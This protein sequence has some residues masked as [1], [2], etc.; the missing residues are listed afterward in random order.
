MKN[1]KKNDNLNNTHFDQLCVIYITRSYN[2]NTHEATL[3]SCVVEV[4]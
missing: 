2:V 1:K 4:R 3:Q